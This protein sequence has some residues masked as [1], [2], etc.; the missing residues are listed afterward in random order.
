M[1]AVAG[2]EA[3]SSEDH[4]YLE[5]LEKFERRFVTQVRKLILKIFLRD[6]MRLELFSRVLILL[7][8]C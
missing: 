8:I 3:L 2:E 6:H 7:G 1:K 4:L 5:F